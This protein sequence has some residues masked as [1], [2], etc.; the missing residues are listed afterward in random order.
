MATIQT[1]SVIGG[2]Y[3]FNL[4]TINIII[5]I[6]DNLITTCLINLLAKS[7]VQGALCL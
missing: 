3:R 6:T 2:G 7:G 4:S 1:Q 5:F